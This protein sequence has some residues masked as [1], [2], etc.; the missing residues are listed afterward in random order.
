VS[1]HRDRAY[2]AG[3]STNWIKD[4]EPDVAAMVRMEDGR[5]DIRRNL[6]ATIVVTKPDAARRQHR[7]AIRLWF[8]EADPVSIHNLLTQRMRP[9]TL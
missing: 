6:R 7:T 4:Q 2:R 1:K 8:Q 9:F 5:G 3:R